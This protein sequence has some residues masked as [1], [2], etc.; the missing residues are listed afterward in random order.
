MSLGPPVSPHAGL[1]SATHWAGQAFPTALQM[2]E[3]L[4]GKEGKI[5]SKTV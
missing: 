5:R 1:R 4:F 3:A 2:E